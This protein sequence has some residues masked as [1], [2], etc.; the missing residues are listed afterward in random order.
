MP[1][2]FQH[3]LSVDLPVPPADVWAVIADYRR[4]PEWRA[5]VKMTVEPAGLVTEGAV[6]RERLRVLGAWSRTTARIQ[7]V[8]PGRGFRFI[9]EDGTIEGT[10]TVERTADGSR[11]TVWLRVTLP[12]AMA[13]LTRFMGWMFRRRVRR[14]LARLQRLVLA[15]TTPAF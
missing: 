4:D 11:L 10:R 13:P 9:S 15:A 8:D 6:T 3:E 1:P 7:D 2:S 14:D 5:A 12:C